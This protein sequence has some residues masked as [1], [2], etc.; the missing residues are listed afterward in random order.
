[1]E[2]TLPWRMLQAMAICAGVALWRFATAASAFDCS[3]RPPCPTGE[4]AISGILC[5]VH[6][7]SRSYSMPRL[8]TWYST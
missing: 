1:M 2:I 5:S 8:P 4:Y 7:G 3:S 6:H